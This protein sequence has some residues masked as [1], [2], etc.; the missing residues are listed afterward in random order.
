MTGTLEIE[1]PAAIHVC[2]FRGKNKVGAFTYFNNDCIVY[3][4]TVE[5]FCSIA[6]RS[7]IGPPEHPTN[8]LTSHLFSHTLHVVNTGFGNSAPE[9]DEIVTYEPFSTHNN[10]RTFIG[11]DVWVGCN[12]FIRRGVTIGDGA[13]VGANSA[14]VKDVEPFMIDG[15]TPARIIRQRFSDKIIERIK[16]SRWWTYNLKRTALEGIRYSDP[17]KALDIIEAAIASGKLEKFAS[18]IHF[19]TV[20]DGKI[21]QET[22]LP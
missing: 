15:G 20:K 17:Q 7:V 12:V 16:S 13:I 10:R 21:M 18:P 19:L 14:V 11:N 5:R 2:D 9:L 4:T 6:H 3:D 8:W 22:R 1:Q